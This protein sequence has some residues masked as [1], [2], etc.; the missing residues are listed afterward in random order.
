MQKKKAATT[1]GSITSSKS[2]SSMNTF[3][4]E[5]MTRRPIMM[6]II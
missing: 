6:R 4:T 2:T 5:P 1:A 3:E